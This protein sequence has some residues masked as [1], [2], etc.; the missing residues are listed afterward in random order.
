MKKVLTIEGKVKTLGAG[1]LGKG[2]TQYLTKLVSES[3]LTNCPYCGVKLTLKNLSL[4]H[5]EPY[6][7]RKD[8]K[9]LPENKA[10]RQHL[11]RLENL[12]IV[13]R[14]CNAR[15][16]DLSH[17]EYLSLL[18]WLDTTPFKDKLLRRLSQSRM[19][20]KTKV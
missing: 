6:A 18:V 7:S 15:K 11:D 17:E 14:R 1:L 20:F 12:H 13:C 16:S 9:P 4:D 2:K 10:I 3:L 8:R 19:V 5:K